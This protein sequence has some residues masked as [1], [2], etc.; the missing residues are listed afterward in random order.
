MPTTIFRSD[1]GA[2]KLNELWNDIKMWD[3]KKYIMGASCTRSQYGLTSG[4]AYSLIG[5]YELNGHKVLKMRNPWSS[6]RYNGP[7]SDND[8]RWTP[9]LRR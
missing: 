1:R 6:E 3:Q 4:H 2:Y 5:A 7:W 8:S 9:S